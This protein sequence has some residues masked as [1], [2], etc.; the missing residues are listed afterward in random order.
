[1]VKS[2]LLF[3]RT[4]NLQL[5]IYNSGLRDSDIASLGMYRNMHTHNN[6]NNFKKQNKADSRMFS[7]NL[8]DENEIFG[9]SSSTAS[10][11]HWNTLPGRSNHHT[12][13]F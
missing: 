5:L 13:S 11:Y 8:E 2:T 6:N 10:V 1:M 3:Q 12:Y 7:K 4:R 9:A